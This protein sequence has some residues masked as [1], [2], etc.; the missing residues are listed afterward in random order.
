MTAAAIT[1]DR[2][3]KRYGRQR[4]LEDVTLSVGAGECIALIG[5]N[6]AGKTTLLKLVLGLTRPDVGRVRVLGAQPFGRAGQDFRRRL[7]YLPE[8]VAFH[9]GM[10]GRETVRFYARLKGACLKSADALLDDVGLA[11]AARRPVRTYSKGMRQRLGLAQAMLGSPGLL[12]LDEPTTGL[13]PTLRHEF[14]ER[15]RALREQGTTMLISSHSLAEI[16]GR[17]DRIA[18]LRRG[19]LVAF[20]SLAELRERSRATVQIR[21]SVAEGAA[22]RVASRLNASERVRRINARSIDLACLA[23][24]KMDLLRKIAAAGGEVQDVEVLAPPLDEVYR[25]YSG[26]D[27]QP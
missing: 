20:G 21:V 4:V 2:V 23:P 24:E 5:H 13:D 16:E 25:H 27:A 14:Y 22:A 9:A 8:N 11:E 17:T 19:R 12:V 7:G 3:A 1:F 6:G 10:S 18:V 26:E 15:V